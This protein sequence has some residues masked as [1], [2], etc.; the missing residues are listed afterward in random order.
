MAIIGTFT[1]IS[2]GGWEG[3]IRTLTINVR[4]RFV[5][6][7]NRENE[8]S[9][10]YLILVGLVELG[11][12]WIHRTKESPAREYLSVQLDDP[13]LA[14]PIAAA[15]FFH[16]GEERARLIWMRRRE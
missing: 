8:R 7:D 12:A 6:N 1:A 4:A 10:D 14:E 3:R 13:T 2:D 16:T 15:L 5:P 11:V 9:P